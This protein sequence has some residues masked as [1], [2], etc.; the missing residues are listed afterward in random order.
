MTNTTQMHTMND[1]TRKG[2]L[3]KDLGFTNAK[4]SL[5]VTF[6]MFDKG[7]SFFN[8]RFITLP[9][10]NSIGLTVAEAMDEIEEWTFKYL[11]TYLE[12]S[13]D[14]I[15]TFISRGVWSLVGADSVTADV[16][17]YKD[18]AMSISEL[19]AYIGEINIAN[20]WRQ[21][22]VSIKNET[23]QA[24]VDIAEIA[25]IISELSEAVEELRNG[26]TS[27]EEYYSGGISINKTFDL[28]PNDPLDDDDNLRKPEGV[29][30]EL[31]DALIRILDYADKRNINLQR[32]TMQK[33]RFNKTRGFRHGG[34]VA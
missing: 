32:A 24:K 27:N 33:L 11:R 12:Y 21:T 14:E 1:L 7:T 29:P 6:K 10:Y 23:L 2:S 16:E 17:V 3:L 4:L 31:A 20:G 18:E 25:L 8:Q 22:D 19:Q 28:D 13:D 30:S 9:E 15:E 5:E 34:K 26:Y